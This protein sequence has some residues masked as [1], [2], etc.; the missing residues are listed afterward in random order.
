[1]IASL[2]GLHS[3]L[4]LKSANYLLADAISVLVLECVH[5]DDFLLEGASWT[6]KH[7]VTVL[8]IIWGSCTEVELLVIGLLL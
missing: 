1:M 8:K 2:L 3:D 6:A 5:T 7:G 4:S